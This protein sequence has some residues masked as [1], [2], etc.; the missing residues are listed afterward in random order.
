MLKQNARLLR[1]DPEARRGPTANTTE[2]PV[3]V[4]RTSSVVAYV[5]HEQAA[6]QMG[7]LAEE[8]W[9]WVYDDSIEMRDLT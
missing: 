7:L 6:E 4:A 8:G 2:N 9:F 5:V 1:R 3:Q